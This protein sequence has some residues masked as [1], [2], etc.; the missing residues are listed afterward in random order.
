MT[1]IR[2][3]AADTSQWDH[4]ADHGV[5]ATAFHRRDWAELWCAHFGG[6]N[7]A[8]AVELTFTDGR[9][10][11]VPF[12]QYLPADAERPRVFLSAGGNYGGPLS[13]DPLTADHHAAVAA[14]LS[15][16]GEVRW[17]SLPDPVAPTASTADG[18]PDVTHLFELTRGADAWERVWRKR[19]ADRKARR[20]TQAGVAVADD[21]SP[22]ALRD[23]TRL[24]ELSAARWNDG[25]HAYDAAFFSRLAAL[26][27]ATLLL[28]YKQGRA[29]A[30]AWLLTHRGHCVYWHG[31][32]DA[33]AFAL[34]PANLLLLTAARRALAAGH[35][36]FDLNPSGGHPGTARFKRSLGAEPHAALLLH[37]PAA[38]LRS[39]G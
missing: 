17:R 24:V 16:R 9:T 36:T 15:Q 28:A 5:R 20:A 7:R 35:H 6:T 32:A 4:A 10:A 22:A 33:D 18:D 29:L 38:E 31:A 2:E 25:H 37:A 26:P 11:V 14:W 3:R 30:G 27:H 8:H 34:R 39:T 23:Y 19:G 12:S 21:K 13:P 1:V